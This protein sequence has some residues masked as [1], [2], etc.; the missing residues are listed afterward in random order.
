MQEYTRKLNQMRVR[1]LE[2]EKLEKELGIP[3]SRKMTNEFI[4]QQ[5]EVIKNE[6]MK[7]LLDRKLMEALGGR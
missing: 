4:K 6:Y 5:S 1:M 7:K 2:R 3:T